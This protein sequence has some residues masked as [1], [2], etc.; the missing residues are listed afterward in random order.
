M[1]ATP[2]ICLLLLVIALLV[3][4]VVAKG[5]EIEPCTANQTA[6]PAN[7]YYWPPDTEVK[8]YTVRNM[9]S[10][11]QKQTLLEV[12]DN[13]SRVSANAGAGVTF[14]YVGDSDGAFNCDACLTVTRREVHKSDRKHYAFFNPMR[15]DEGGLLISAWIDL[16]VATQDPEALRG[17]LAHELGH[18]MGL[19][20]CTSCKKK[21]TIMNAFP[22]IN[23]HNGLTEPSACDAEVVQQ[24]YQLERRVRSN[25]VAQRAEG[26]SQ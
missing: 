20:D 15:Q 16:D 26:S 13:W 4:C 18:G 5:Q 2:P 22:G 24:V 8:V 3:P 19:W 1:R 21:Q 14:T 25:A 10:S 12:M 9:F 6:P 23:K 11:E 17:F 7:A